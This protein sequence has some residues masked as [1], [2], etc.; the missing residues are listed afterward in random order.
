MALS[1]LSSA[2][3]DAKLKSTEAALTDNVAGDEVDGGG[4]PL[5]ADAGAC[6]SLILS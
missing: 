1:V 2:T 6:S 4:S 3:G 5:A